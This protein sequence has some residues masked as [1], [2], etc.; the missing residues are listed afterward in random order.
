MVNPFPKTV[1]MLTNPTGWKNGT[2]YSN[3]VSPLTNKNNPYVN[4]A[5][6]S[7][8]SNTSQMTLPKSQTDQSKVASSTDSPNAESIAQV[9]AEMDARSKLGV[10]DNQTMD[11]YLKSKTSTVP[12]QTNADMGSTG[13][14]TGT[15]GTTTSGTGTTKTD[16]QTGAIS[17]LANGGNVTT[18]D[19]VNY[20]FN[21]YKQSSKDVEDANQELK[22]KELQYS[23][24]IGDIEGRPYTSGVAQGQELV[25]Q[26]Q[27]NASLP[28]YT[29]NVANA[30][31]AKGQL[32]SALG[33]AIP[34]LTKTINPS[35]SVV[36]T[37]NGNTIAGLSST[38]MYDAIN[39]IITKV[40]NGKMG[41]DDGV[42]ALNAYGQPGV[43]ALQKGLG[44]DFNVQQSNAN[45][46]AQGASTLQ[47]GT[48]GGQITK[49]AASAN[50]ALD[51]LSS[52][53]QNLPD[54]QK[55]GVSGMIGIEQGIGQFF[56][57]TALRSYQV[58]L[59]DARSQIS[60]VL[61]T[62]G[63]T[64]TD[65]DTMA[66]SYLPDNMTTGQFES[67]LATVRTLIQQKVGAYTT[68]STGTNTNQ[69]GTT[70]TTMFGS[71]NSK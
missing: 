18:A 8:A 14:T 53:F 44:S 19:L 27:Y 48:T 45:A 64:P 16:A 37:T 46:A 58:A 9:K 7:Y 3:N 17:S 56:G 21:Q 22:N 42:Q 1:S 2:I 57:N 70:G 52:N 66:K 11:D 6:P 47:T 10:P 71:F 36:S 50:S 38:S 13:S 28:A 5:T 34:E 43:D 31:N 54:L 20:L 26:N 51:T 63:L 25:K 32:T 12:P 59:N 49:A 61:S 68:S 4:P 67:S 15:T 69:S 35:E 24:D 39:N 55:L 41:Y 60:A 29:E 65:A 23:A 30:I 62:S 40:K 33:S